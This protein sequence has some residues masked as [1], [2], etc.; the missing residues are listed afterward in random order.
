MEPM[1]SNE[2]QA[3]VAAR[4]DEIMA[5]AEARDVD[6]LE[7][8][9][10]F[11]PRYTKFDDWEPLERQDAATARTLEREAISGADGLETQIEDL[12]VDVFGATAVA[13]FVF[14]YSFSAGDGRMAVR[15]RSTL[16]L[17]RDDERGWLI[18]HEHFSPFSP[19]QG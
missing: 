19:Q 1:E 7:S 16:V 14:A 3:E 9:H 12:K 17:V 15:A 6:R 5:A 13:T 18:V 8:Y 4:L 10:L 11:G 2:A